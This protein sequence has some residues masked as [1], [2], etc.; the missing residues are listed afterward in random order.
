MDIIGSSQYVSQLKLDCFTYLY[1]S[2][3]ISAFRNSSTNNSALTIVN[4]IIRT[5]IKQQK[6]KLKHLSSP[7]DDLQ[8][9][10]LNILFCWCYCFKGM[11]TE[12]L[13]K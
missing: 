1:L 13:N 7:Q 12:P 10:F 8:I 3:A 4:E 2:V 11:M 9:I 5:F 6:I